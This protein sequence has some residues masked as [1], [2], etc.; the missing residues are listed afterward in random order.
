MTSYDETV[1]AEKIQKAI[2]GLLELRAEFLKTGPGM[3]LDEIR[4]AIHLGRE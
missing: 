2:D 4:A 1:D 3:S